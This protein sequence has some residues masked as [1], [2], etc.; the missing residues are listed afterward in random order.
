MPRLALLNMCCG[1][2][3]LF[4]AAAAGAFVAN[5]V[6]AAYMRDKVML[7]TW[8]MALLKSAHG[9]ANLFGMLHILFG[10]TMPYS[11]WTD[12]IKRFQS[13][14]LACG[15]AAIGP[16]LVLRATEVPGVGFDINGAMVGALLSAALVTLAT[17]AAGIGA[18]L[19]RRS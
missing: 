5:D 4:A 19:W 10:L 11:I 18:K 12:R 2:F 16:G 15:T 3:V 17:H 6:T 8:S 7:A 13:V 1:F 14:G 9:H